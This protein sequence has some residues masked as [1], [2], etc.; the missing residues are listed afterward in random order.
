LELLDFPANL[1]RGKA[2]EV[3][4]PFGAGGMVKLLDLH[5]LQVIGACVP[6]LYVRNSQCD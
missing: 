6:P 3:L 2:T 5:F 4:A 1:W